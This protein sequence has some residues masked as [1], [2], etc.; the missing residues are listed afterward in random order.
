VRNQVYG[1]DFLSRVALHDLS[2]Q[3]ASL[4]EFQFF[5]H[6]DLLA[7]DLDRSHPPV[8]PLFTARLGVRETAPEQISSLAANGDDVNVLARLGFEKTIGGLYHVG[9]ESAGKSL[10][11]A[12]YD[13]QDVLLFP[14]LKQRMTRLS[15]NRVV[16]LGA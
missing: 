3:I 13:E 1:V 16:D 14:A 11:A 6:T 15:G 10:V 8:F 2:G 9:I 5:Q 7:H 12:D 4:S